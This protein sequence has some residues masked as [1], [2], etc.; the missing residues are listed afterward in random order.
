MRL[1]GGLEISGNARRLAEFM[2]ALDV[3]IS[4]LHNQPTC[5]KCDYN[6]T[7]IRP[8]CNA[9]LTPEQLREMGGK[10]YWHVG[11]QTDSPE[12]HWKILDSFVAKR[13]EDYGYGK[14]WLAYAYPP[15]H[16]DREAWTAEWE[17]DEFGHKCSKCGEYLPSGDDE[18][19]P[20]FCPSC[21]RA[22]TE[23][24]LAELE[25]RLRG[26]RL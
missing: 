7:E 1:E 19:T 4:A 18:I 24:A 16:I 3:A 11:L 14:R 6:A 13:P 2:E 12:P 9:S 23:D 10:P 21:G 25:T 17:V 20:Q 8:G 5:E 15:A 26:E 22:T